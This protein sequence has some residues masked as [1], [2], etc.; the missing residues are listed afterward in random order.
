MRASCSGLSLVVLFVAASV[1]LGAATPDARL[2]EAVKQGDRSLV[3]ALLKAGVDANTPLPDGA[4]PLH[5]AAY[6]NDLETAELL[7]QAGANVNAVNDL[8]IAPLWLAATNGHLPL[9][10]RLLTAGADPNLGP[11]TG[12]TP[13]MRAIRSGNIELV[14]VLIAH[15][16]DVNA[17]EGSRGQTALMYA[18]SEGK[19]EIVRL[20]L[21][22]KADVHARSATWPQRFM[23][24]CNPYVSEASHQ[25][26]IQRGGYTPLLF[27]VRT[28]DLE[29]ARLL[30][31]AGAHVNDVAPEKTSALVIAAFS[32]HGKMG[33]F[34]L[35]HGADP[36]HA[37]AGYWALHAAVLREDA[38]LTRALLARGADPNVRLRNG[39]PQTRYGG[40]WAFHRD[41]VGATPLWLAAGLGNAEI[42]RTLLS[43]G[44]DPR[45]IPTNGTTML[46]AAAQTL[47]PKATSDGRRSYKIPEK[48]ALE[49][50]E[51]VL[52]LGIDINAANDAGDTAIHLAADLRNNVVIEYLAS[53][54]AAVNPKNK[55]G[56]TPLDKVLSCLPCLYNAP[57]DLDSTKAAA[58]QGRAETAEVLRKL[59]G[60]SDNVLGL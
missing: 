42:V 50:V 20:L 27:A 8:H 55:L 4:T 36:H 29:S 33:M 18:V 22:A 9:V 44:A 5:W 12:G 24:C 41:W 25:I 30:V 26:T 19:A 60:T 57:T 51:I 34:L 15:R 40:Q 52:G 48:R 31:A 39:S 28:G 32:G 2:P 21:D 23:V 3:R 43:A 17:K 46:I 54:G 38:A 53:K 13:L 35:D 11:E 7:I 47:T 56:Q 14:R 16:A 37:E 49:V 58:A 1:G 6:R 59:G 45:L 10:S